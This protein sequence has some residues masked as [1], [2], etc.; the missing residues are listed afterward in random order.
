MHVGGEASPHGETVGAGLFLREAP[1]PRPSAL[2]GYKVFEQPRPLHAGLDLDQAPFGV[3]RE[4]PVEPA[5]VDQ[6]AVG[7]EGLCPHGVAA[8]GD[9]NGAALAPRRTDRVAHCV[10]RLGLHNPV[11]ARRVQ[12]GMDVV[13][14]DAGST[15]RHVGPCR[16]QGRRPEKIP[17]IDH[18]RHPSRVIA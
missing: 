9:T 8:A 13:D 6:H 17:A 14:D 4:D 15:R 11:D 12:A 10:E 16:R 1:L 7:G 18:D 2:C 3:E 5:D